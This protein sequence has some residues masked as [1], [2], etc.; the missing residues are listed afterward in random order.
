MSCRC[1]LPRGGALIEAARISPAS[2]TTRR[3]MTLVFASANDAAG[4]AHCRYWP[5]RPDLGE[6]WPVRL[7]ATSEEDYLSFRHNARDGG[8]C[9][10]L[11]FA[12]WWERKPMKLKLGVLALGIVCASQATAGSF[13]A[14][15][16]F[17]DSSV[18]SG[19]WSG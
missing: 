11:R 12:G 15:Y 19:W 17:G 5:A 6:R 8:G 16:S 1:R 4:H 3:R 14:F 7:V 18:D 2:S 10:I 9:G 13:N